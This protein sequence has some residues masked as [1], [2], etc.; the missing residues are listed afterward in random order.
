MRVVIFLL[1][2]IFL[3]TTDAFSQRVPPSKPVFIKATSTECHVCGRN[4]WD[5]FKD[6]II[7]HEKEATIFAVHPLEESLL[8]S[9]S[10]VE[11]A[12]N[13]PLFYGT[14]TYYINNNNI[15]HTW[16]AASKETVELF[17]KQRVTVH[18][19]IDYHIENQE[20]KVNVK[21]QFLKGT[22]RPYYLSVYLI[23][24][25]VIEQQQLRGPE[26][27]HSKILRKRFGTEDFGTLYSPD[28]IEANQ[29][30]EHQFSMP[31][32]AKWDPN[33]LEIAAIIWERKGEKYSVINSNT[34][35]KPALTTSLNQLEKLGINLQVQPN[36]IEQQ[37]TISINLPS[38]QENLHLF[39]VNPLGQ[40]IQTIK[41]GNLSSGKHQFELNASDFNL[42]GLHFLV[43]E[44]DGAR[45]SRKAM[46]K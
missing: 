30:F 13:F 18:P 45:L 16:I 19:F 34:A 1:S 24:D 25:Q 44:K 10:S 20:V 31:I 40:T 2:S 26:D 36:L 23:E 46:F 6:I 33:N 15:D 22:N 14:P 17:K 32:D 11:V 12:S 27:K 21:T 37:A 8:F 9:N 38:S 5:Q 35:L 28:P 42:S 7:L 29:T 39:I 43:L 3:F 41:T 4:S